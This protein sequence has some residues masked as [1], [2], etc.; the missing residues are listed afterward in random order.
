MNHNLFRS[1]G[2]FRDHTNL[3]CRYITDS[4]TAQA[5][6]IILY[7]CFSRLFAFPVQFDF[8]SLPTPQVHR[9]AAVPD[10]KV[11]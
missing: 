9:F 7:K 6:V 3:V 4:H 11:P 1:I 5:L 2:G 8:T 10:V